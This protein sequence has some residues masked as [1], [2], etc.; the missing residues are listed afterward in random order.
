MCIHMAWIRAHWTRTDIH[1]HLSK[2]S[3]SGGHR[4]LAGRSPWGHKE[5][6]TTPQLNNNTADLFCCTVEINT[7]I[8]KQL[9]SSK[10]Q[11]QRIVNGQLFNQLVN[12]FFETS[13][14]KKNLRRT[15]FR[16]LPF[17]WS[18]WRLGSI[19]RVQGSLTDFIYPF[20]CTSLH[21]GVPELYPSI[22]NQSSTK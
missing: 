16:K 14:K 18:T 19:Q 10:N 20:P 21:L 9:Y 4:S 12:H 11:L 3:D 8:V 5:S 7:T 1:M 22:I 6:D 2:L 17:L 13:K 15:R